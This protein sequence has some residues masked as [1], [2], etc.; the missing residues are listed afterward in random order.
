M[1]GTED[2][3]RITALL[4]EQELDRLRQRRA[5]QAQLQGQLDQMDRMREAAQADG[6]AVTARQRIGADTLWQGWMLAKRAAILRDMA[7]A[8]AREE[9]A[10]AGARRA[11]SRQQAARALIEA[12][13]RKA[14]RQRLKREGDGLDAL[15]TLRLGPGR[16]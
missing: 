5:A 16:R 14:R 13:A 1:S 3:T 15:A 10:L 6:G 9:E 11:F 4:M 7:L 12:E 2:L 8:R